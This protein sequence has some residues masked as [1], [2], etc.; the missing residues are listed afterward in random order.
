[1]RIST[2]DISRIALTKSMFRMPVNIV[3]V[4]KECGDQ[5]V[6]S[7]RFVSARSRLDNAPD[8]A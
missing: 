5:S 2:L 4:R 1:M 7:V 6:M 3:Q 8:S